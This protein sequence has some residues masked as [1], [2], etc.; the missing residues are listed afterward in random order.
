MALA[1]ALL[2]NAAVDM[3]S[4]NIPNNNEGWGRIDITRVIQPAAAVVALDQQQAFTGT[5]QQL[6]RHF[7]VD[8]P[9]Q[10]S[11]VTLA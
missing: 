6:T 2:V 1:K 9:G 4:A 5:G 3:G 8:D 10:P 7:V 11:R